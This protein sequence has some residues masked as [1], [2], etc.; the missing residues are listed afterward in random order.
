MAGCGSES[1][2]VRRWLHQE[3]APRAQDGKVAV[4]VKGCTGWRYVVEE[5]SAA[6]FDPHVSLSGGGGAVWVH[7]PEH[8]PAVGHAT[9]HNFAGRREEVAS[10][11]GRNP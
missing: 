6:G 5:I 10:I 1:S 3:L 2:S 9:E 7:S 11:P 4:A 8:S